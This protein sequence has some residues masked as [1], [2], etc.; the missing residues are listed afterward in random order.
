MQNRLIQTSQ[1][2]DQGYSDTYPFSIPWFVHGIF[3]V[4]LIYDYATKELGDGLNYSVL[5]IKTKIV[6][7]HAADSKPVKQEVNGTVILPPL[8]FP[9]PTLKGSD[10]AQ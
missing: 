6:I 3:R 10:L 9:A 8:L 7:C 5:Q 4:N 1:R 2:G